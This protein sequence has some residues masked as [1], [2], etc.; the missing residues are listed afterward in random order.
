MKHVSSVAI[1]FSDIDAFGHVNNA[2]YLTYFEEARVR[3]FDD[4]VEWGYDWTNEGVILA[5]AEVDFIV[6]V[7]FKDEI[8]IVTYCSRIGTKSF[9]LSYQMVKYIE[10]KE[11]LLSACTTVM[12][13]F[14]YQKKQSVAVPENW[15][16]ALSKYSGD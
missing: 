4:V 2:V 15:K 12:V 13:A 1:R 10:G 3:F 11:V 5:R 9:D 7:H 14:D 6:P 8:K 16:N